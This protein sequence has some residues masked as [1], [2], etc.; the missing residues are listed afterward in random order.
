MRIHTDYLNRTDFYAAVEAEQLAGRLPAD[1]VIVVTEH[2]SQS[3]RGA[4]ELTVGASAHAPGRR[5]E[6]AYGYAYATPYSATP[7]EWG[8]VLANLYGR[9]ERMVCGR[10]SAPT[11]AD[12]EDFDDK[13][14]LTYNPAELFAALED[15]DYPGDPY[16]FVRAGARRAGRAGVTRLTGQ[17]LEYAQ[18]AEA[19]GYGNDG[20]ARREPRTVE[21][22]ARFCHDGP[23]TTFFDLVR[24]GCPEQWARSAVEAAQVAA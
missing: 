19:R 22:Y 11:Y 9:D 10:V 3:H 1:I 15:A 21:A 4:F 2:G 18:S 5:R 16:P 20:W 17:Q 24:T 7:D 14:A 8:W 6:S 12:R 13:T 23:R